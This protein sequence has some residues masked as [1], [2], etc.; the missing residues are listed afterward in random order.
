[1]C[2][3]T[4][5]LLLLAA[6]RAGAPPGG[7]PD[8][9]NTGPS[10]TDTGSTDTGP[11]DTVPTDTGPTDA[12]GDGSP[13]AEDCAPDDPAIF[14]GAPEVCDGTDQDCDGDVD[15]GFGVTAYVDADQDG[16]GAGA[17]AEVAGCAT[18]TGYAAVEGD[19]DDADPGAYPGGTELS[20]GAD[21]DSDGTA[22]DEAVDASIWY[23]DGDGDSWGVTDRSVT[24]CD[25][26][27]GYVAR[28]GD[29]GDATAGISP[30]ATEVCDAVDDD[31]N[32]TTD[33]GAGACP[34]L[35][36]SEAIVIVTGSGSVESRR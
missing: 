17:A 2:P 34:D 20:D 13:D 22:D 29:C 10:P 6:C 21:N 25:P 23:A 3:L 12:D 26:P 8:L 9:G 16:Y 5:A 31:C 11:T 18:P 15:E 7:K 32:G 27:A 30:A 24:A 4:L 19:C 35:V 28:G 1:M 33:D 36:P 14:P